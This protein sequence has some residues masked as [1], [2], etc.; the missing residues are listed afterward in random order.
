MKTTLAKNICVGG[1]KL[2][3]PPLS[4]FLETVATVK[5][6]KTEAEIER[7]EA[8]VACQG[9][10]CPPHPLLPVAIWLCDGVGG[11]GDGGGGLQGPRI[12]APCNA[13]VGWTLQH[14]VAQ[15]CHCAFGQT[16]SRVRKASAQGR[17]AS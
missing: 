17:V 12:M 15:P 14:H 5:Y 9:E 10:P 11:G 2:T 1:G 7:G 13:N 8:P 3:L 6:S 4:S 16:D